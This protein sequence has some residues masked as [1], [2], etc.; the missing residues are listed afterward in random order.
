MDKLEGAGVH[1]SQTPRVR[2]DRPQ[3]DWL[4]DPELESTPH[5]R[6][7]APGSW[8]ALAGTPRAR[9]D[10]SRKAGQDSLG[11]GPDGKTIEERHEDARKGNGPAT[12]RHPREAADTTA[13]R[14]RHRR[15]N[16]DG[17]RNERPPRGAAAADQMG[18]AN[19]VLDR[20]RGAG[21][22]E[23]QDRD[24]DPDERSAARCTRSRRRPPPR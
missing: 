14:W 3:I 16:A 15:R 2:G 8:L 7:R 1:H 4:S 10:C 9:G 18:R 19:P 24:R 21:H 5:A 22:A 13:G 23:R 6:G 12:A 17:R 20:V 11:K